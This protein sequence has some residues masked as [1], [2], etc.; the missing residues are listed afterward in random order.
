ML[1]KV[2]LGTASAVAMMGVSTTAY[3]GN[4]QA[5]LKRLHDMGDRKSVV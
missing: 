1:W 4:S 5:L 2:L 3:A